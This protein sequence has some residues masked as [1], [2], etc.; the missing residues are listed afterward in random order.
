MGAGTHSSWAKA[1]ELIQTISLS[2]EFKKLKYRDAPYAMRL[3]ETNCM[4]YVSLNPRSIYDLVF[5]WIV[6][7]AKGFLHIIWI[8][9]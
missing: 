2:D 7:S 1:N 4:A 3:I 9:R 6:I 5:L 8:M